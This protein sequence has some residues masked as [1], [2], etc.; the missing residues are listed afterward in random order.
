ME[1]SNSDLDALADR[2]AEE[3]RE[4]RDAREHIFVA[5]IARAYKV[6]HKRV[7]QQLKGVESHT[8]QKLVNYKLSKIQEAALIQYI[9]TLN[10]I[11]IRVH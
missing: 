6:D 3:V 11:S 7:S 8:S 4:R 9:Q 5:K 2:A 10:E 1:F